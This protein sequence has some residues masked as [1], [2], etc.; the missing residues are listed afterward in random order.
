MQNYH[1]SRLKAPSLTPISNPYTGDKSSLACSKVW[2]PFCEVLPA[3]VNHQQ[4]CTT[5][6]QPF[7]FHPSWVTFIIKAITFT[8]WFFEVPKHIGVICRKATSEPENEA[9]KG[10]LRVSADKVG[11]NINFCDAHLNIFP[12]PGSV[13]SHHFESDIPRSGQANPA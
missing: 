9:S 3:V 13:S 4:L 7:L 6:A 12:L 1:Y 10:Q 8:A 2:T 5:P 11:I